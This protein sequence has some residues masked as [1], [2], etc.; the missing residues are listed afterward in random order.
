MME[1]VAKPETKLYQIQ[2]GFSVT[3]NGV[4]YACIAGNFPCTT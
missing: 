3:N 2:R 1:T 4:F